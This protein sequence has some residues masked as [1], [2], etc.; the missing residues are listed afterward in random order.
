MAKARIEIT[1]NSQ[2]FEQ[3]AKR[4][5]ADL[6]Q[7]NSNAE[8]TGRS[9]SEFGNKAKAAFAGIVSTAA[10]GTFVKQMAT[11]RGQFQQY[12]IALSTMLQS[13]EKAATLMGELLELAAKTPFDLQGVVEGAKQLMAYGTS[14]EEMIETL[15]MLGDV[16]AGLSIP[17]GDLVYLYGTTMT[18]GRVFTMDMRQFMARGIPMAEELAKQFGVTKEAVSGLV[19][20]GKVGA[21]AITKAFQSMTSE[22]GKFENLMVRQS[23]SITGQISNLQ[24]S[25]QTMFNDLGKMNEGIIYDAIKGAAWLVEHYEEIGKAVIELIAIYGSYKAAL[26]AVTASH[27]AYILIMQQAQVEMAL[28]QAQGIALSAAQAKMAA[29]T[30]LLSGAMSNLNKVIKANP[31]ALIA[32]AVVGLGYGIYKL[33]TR[34]TELEKALKSANKEAAEQKSELIALQT[35]LEDSN[36]AYEERKKALDKI[37]EIVPAYHAS[38][39]NEGVLI[40]NNKEALDDYVAS[41]ETTIELETLQTK[42]RDAIQKKLALES[43]EGN[44]WTKIN[45]ITGGKKAQQET[46]SLFIKAYED[47]IE[48]ITKRIAELSQKKIGKTGTGK[49]GKKVLEES[50]EDLEK[51]NKWLIDS[52]RKANDEIIDLEIEYQR[53]QIEAMQDGVAKR[54]ALFELGTKENLIAIQ[55]FVRDALDE[56][57]E[58][59]KG[60]DF[61]LDYGHIEQGVDGLWAFKIAE[62]A[63]QLTPAQKALLQTKMDL[64]NQ[65]IIDSWIKSDV[66]AGLQMADDL[67]E[68]IDKKL[69]EGLSKGGFDSLKEQASLIF[70]DISELSATMIKQIIANAEDYISNNDV[71]DEALAQ[72]RQAIDRANKYLAEKNPW[73]ALSDALADYNK[74]LKAYENAVKAQD[75]G[76]QKQAILD[77][78]SALTVLQTAYQQIKTEVGG[79]FSQLSET[80]DLAG[81]NNEKLKMAVDTMGKVF[82]LAIDVAS[83]IKTG[84][85]SLGGVVSSLFSLLNILLSIEK[86]ALA[87]FTKEVADDVE[88]VNKRLQDMKDNLVYLAG[89][90][91]NNWFTEDAFQSIQNLNTALVQSKNDLIF[92]AKIL[93][94]TFRDLDAFWRRFEELQ[95]SY[96]AFMSNTQTDVISKDFLETYFTQ[97]EKIQAL[98]QDVFGMFGKSGSFDTDLFSA[99]DIDKIKELREAFEGIDVLD[100]EIGAQITSI[101]GGLDN[102]IEQYELLQDGIRSIVGDISGNILST[103]N[104]MW[105]EIREGGETT[106]EDLADA[107]KKNISE[108]ID[109][110]VSQQLWATIMGGYF[111]D[112][113]EGLAAAIATGGD[114]GNILK[115][116]DDFWKNMNQGLMDYT[117]AYEAFLQSAESHGWNMGSDSTGTGDTEAAKDSIRAMREE[118]ARLQEQWESMSDA[119][120][121]SGD[122]KEL[123]GDITDLK[124][125]LEIAENLYNQT[126]NIAGSIDDIN[127][128]LSRLNAEL[129]ALSP[130]DREGAKGDEI[131]RDIA[132]Y[133]QLLENAQRI[134][135]T[136][137]ESMQKL[138]ESK[139]AK[140]ELYQKW[141]ELYGE[142]SATEMM[143]D[144]LKDAEAYLNELRD[145]ISGLQAKVT[146]GTATDEDIS[147]LTAW[148]QQYADIQNAAAQA[149]EEA[150]QRSYDA[151]NESL[152]NQIEGARTDYEK[153]GILWQEWASVNS[154]YA[155]GV[156]GEYLRQYEDELTKEIE[157]LSREIEKGLRDKYKTDDQRKAET[158]E[159]YRQDIE[160]AEQ[161]LQDMD[162]VD[163]IRKQRDEYLS[164]LA[165]VAIESS[166]EYQLIFGDLQEVSADAFNA[167]MDN[168]RKSVEESTELTEEAKTALLNLL[169][170]TQKKWDDLQAEKEVEKVKEKFSDLQSVMGDVSGLLNEMGVSDTFS[171]MFSGLQMIIDGYGQL[172]IAIE[173]AKAA[174]TAMNM[175]TAFGAIATMITGLIR[176][177]GTLVDRIFTITDIEGPLQG[178]V[179]TYD[180]LTRA[181]DRSVGAQKKARQEEAAQNLKNQKEELEREYAKEASKWGF[182][183]TILG[184]KIQILGPDQ[185]VLDELTS[186][187]NEVETAMQQLGDTMKS[188]FLQTDYESF[189]DALSEILTSPWD[190]FEDMMGAVDDLVDTTLDRI[191]N[192]WLTTKFLQGKIDAALENLYA[193]GDP[194]EEAYDKF[195]EAVKEASAYYLQ[196]ADKLGIGNYSSGSSNSDYDTIRRIS[197]EDFSKWLGEWRAQRIALVDNG[198]MLKN[199]YAQLKSL[200]ESPTAD[201]EL[202]D[203]TR[204]I[205]VNTAI[206]PVLLPQILDTLKSNQ[207]GLK[208]YGY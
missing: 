60:Q 15:T 190:S 24:D 137:L 199:I 77:Q 160:Y 159:D 3:A 110:M 141:I 143:G 91:M 145:G 21:D 152:Q 140:W 14:A 123:F 12:E 201:P 164:E 139:E 96:G 68:S 23:A 112:L 161:I 69:K 95:E 155:E 173:T 175:A 187:I 83:M 52:T 104:S 42:L 119:D 146:A 185:G 50:K 32:A 180:K 126:Y 118:L 107:A 204:R 99:L 162:L 156:E 29:T 84:S 92:L 73:K 205:E 106:F 72:Y 113:G 186:Q 188:D 62:S 85:V 101:I 176:S 4:V 10:V 17:L 51:Y 49:T 5:N 132:Y 94:T 192:K 182:S 169:D 208:P 194:T 11:V 6:R 206:L 56:Q 39:T 76:A 46:I 13:E 105:K 163:E 203:L 115:V 189:S 82:D 200:A 135:E 198:N 177:V 53:E 37:Q 55:R 125:K 120:R 202:L 81:V 27:K 131:K 116:F 174:Q 108:V 147:Q 31:Y 103:V 178:L 80:L 47:E 78:A 65:M 44:I 128:Q 151:W 35:I 129:N 89:I 165:N 43:G 196:E 34:Q 75:V 149:A 2:S 184:K 64:L 67:L 22:G 191:T 144:M 183:F 179:D 33:S 167:A 170:E 130:E 61:T 16:A 136:E 98:I 133:E 122:G 7:M 8:T 127:A 142:D 58:L 193:A 109:Q 9:V 86:N 157:K 114:S 71:S 153:L 57:A 207:N 93:N 70:A 111:D 1:G 41:L 134:Q 66:D 26:I 172:Q 197:A 121:K 100:D 79:I 90:K 18:Q 158:L 181:I 28:A 59:L 38:L 138:I 20:E 87:L 30:K 148:E 166:E 150:A 88:K 36:V 154:Q 40:N 63:L 48:E 54:K 45:R 195:R 171:Q 19:T 102:V 74:A 25:I 97:F 117:S 124:K 168:I